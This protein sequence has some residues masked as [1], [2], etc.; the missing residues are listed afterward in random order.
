MRAA[1]RAR[2]TPLGHACCTPTTIMPSAAPV[3]ASPEADSLPCTGKI[4]AGP[5]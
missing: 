3:G 1:C 5:G 2:L 4:G